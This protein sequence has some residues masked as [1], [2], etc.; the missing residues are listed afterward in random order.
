MSWNEFWAMVGNWFV[1][2]GKS[3][4]SWGANTGIKIIISLLV[5]FI[6]FK[7]INA[8]AKK[9]E[10]AGEKKTLENEKH[11]V[12]TDK[13]V[14]KTLAYIFKLVLKIVV[15]ICL[16]GYLGIDTS[17]L[18]ALIASFG[19]CIGLAVNGALSNLAGGVLIILTRPFRVDDYIEAQG[20]AGTVSDIHITNTKLITPDNKV[21][22]IPNG[23][24]A[25]GNILNYSE[26]DTRR[27]DFSFSI[28]YGADHEKAK[29]ILKE[30]CD[31]H[32][33]VLKDPAPFIRVGEHAA[34]SINIT[35]RVW[36]KS[37]D[38]WTVHFDILEKVKIEFDNNGIEIPFDQL[39][40]HIKND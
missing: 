2:A 33:L 15:A 21:I 32:E 40:V 27:V 28:A 34:S 8:I 26:K 30:I 7:I 11:L 10:K 29:A 20:Y 38:Y 31:N 13:T 12:K 17:G 14:M 19:V 35:T 3:I 36:T 4:V 37:A 25:N 23:P 9:I 18:T 22:Y 24:L 5:L 16:I 1:D 39:D 6:S